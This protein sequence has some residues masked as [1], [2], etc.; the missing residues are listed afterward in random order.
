MI[1]LAVEPEFVRREMKGLF[2]DI[3][4]LGNKELSPE[5]AFYYAAA[6]HLR[7]AQIHPFA[8]GNGR[9][10]RLL[11]K[12]FLASHIGEMAWLIPSEEHYWNNRQAY[13]E[14]INLGVNY[15]ELEYDKCLPFLVMLVKAMEMR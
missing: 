4:I 7:F 3:T 1:Y 12:W 10:V 9:V 15:Y 8:D 13:Y 11:E 6:I 14:N 2:E 5:E